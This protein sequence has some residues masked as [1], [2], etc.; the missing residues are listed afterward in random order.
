MIIT[1]H[2][3][4]FAKPIDVSTLLEMGYI[5]NMDDKSLHILDFQQAFNGITNASAASGAFSEVISADGELGYDFSWEY[6]EGKKIEKVVVYAS[7]NKG[8]I[9]GSDPTDM[10]IFL[11]GWDGAWNALGN[12]GTFTDANSLVKTI[13]SSDQTTF[14]TRIR[15]LVSTATT[16]AR[17]IVELEI[18][19]VTAG[20]LVLNFV[21]TNM[22]KVNRGALM[23]AFDGVTVAPLSDSIQQQV[24]GTDDGEHGVIF[25]KPYKIEKA[26]LYSSSDFGFSSL[27]DPT[28]MQIDLEGWNGSSWIA[29]GNT[30][31]FTD[32]NSISK[33]II[34]SD[35][36]TLFE[37]VRSLIST[38]MASQSRILT[39]AEYFVLRAA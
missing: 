28:D 16:A 26:I 13:T 20:K 21:E 1:R 24:S 8:Y 30:G 36:I 12:T 10:V 14:F 5:G 33:T 37:K 11:E 22:S 38:A 23:R 32:A 4:S 2:P 18:H 29:L 17:N 15:V 39:E 25:H 19:E 27:G 7:N 9:T 31:T 34:S 35:Q 6:P 3:R